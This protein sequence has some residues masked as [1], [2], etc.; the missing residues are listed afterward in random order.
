[1]FGVPVAWWGFLY[2]LWAFF[3]IFFAIINSSKPFGKSCAEAVLFI[4]LIS[5]L[6]TFFKIYQLISLGVICPVCVGMYI[7]NFG[8]FLFMMKS[9]KINF[10]DIIQV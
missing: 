9:L 3:T 4:S 2:Y 10:K 8:I 6:F 7:S 5:V 1:M